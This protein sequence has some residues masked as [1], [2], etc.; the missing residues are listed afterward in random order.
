MSR[1]TKIIYLSYTLLSFMMISIVL[2]VITSRLLAYFQVPESLAVELAIDNDIS[3]FYTPRYEWKS[4]ENEGR[5][6]EEFTLKKIT[7][8]YLA[9][10]YYMDLYYFSEKEYGLKDYQTK[11]ARAKTMGF[12]SAHEQQGTKERSTTLDHFFELKMYSDDG[13]AAVL[14]DE[15]VQYH[16]IFE[17]DQLIT[18]YYDT[19]KYDIMLLLEDNYW[20]IRHKIRKEVKQTELGNFVQADSVPQVQVVGQQF[21]SQGEAFLSKGINY[22]SASHPWDEFWDHFDTTVLKQDLQLVK[23]LNLNTIRVFIPY[24]QFGAQNVEEEY[25]IKLQQLL[26]IADEKELKVIITLFDFFLS[27]DV[28]HWTK[29]DRHVEAIIRTIGNHP[30]LFSWDVKNEPDLDYESQGET[31]VNE[32]LTFIIR[33]IKTYA[34][35]HLVTIGWS[36][37]EYLRSH[38][39]W[40]DYYS[41]HYYEEADRLQSY[42][43][44]PLD[45]PVLLEE[46][47][48]HSYNSWWYPY[49]RSNEDQAEYLKEI[50]KVI[51]KN[52]ISFALWTL[53]D[54]KSIP[55]NVVGKLY[56]RKGIQKNF[57]LIN[58]RDKEKPAYE[59]VKSFAGSYQIED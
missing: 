13:T 16:R 59:V 12:V 48:S 2:F 14:T 57:G 8:D 23:D 18:S 32:W 24:E 50:L 4:L 5:E 6:M 27:Y 28:Q 3:N 58:R 37:P 52:E 36:T 45:K 43:E 42:F 38:S 53:Y 20:R 34:P 39:E 10:Y 35:H 30:A 29:A 47:G 55:D 9:S 26:D 1:N 40:V 15:Q 22:Y 46:T 33:R 44:E 21:R 11:K 41:F 31:V 25:L 7:A 17:G 56:W 19:I 49:R 51:D 54:F